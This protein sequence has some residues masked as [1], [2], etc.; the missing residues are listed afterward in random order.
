M[1]A[2]LRHGLSVMIIA[3]KPLVRNVAFMISIL[4]LAKEMPGD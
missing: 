4:F 3:L 2:I 1:L